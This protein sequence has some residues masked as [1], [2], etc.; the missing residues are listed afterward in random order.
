MKKKLLI[1]FSSTLIV[2]LLS[3]FEVYYTNGCPYHTGSPADGLTC[4]SC[5]YGGV[6][7]PTISINVL[8]A[9][10]P[11]NMYNPGTTYTISV[12]GIGYTFYGF[13]V[14]IINSQSSIAS[15]V[16]DFGI[17]NSISPSETINS[18]LPGWT[19]SDIMHTAPKSSSF[20]FEWTAPLSG[21]G[22]LYC[23][24]L[25]VNYN[26]STSGDHASFINMTLSPAVTNDVSEVLANDSILNVSIFPNPCS[27]SINIDYYL[28]SAT[29]VQIRLFD[30]NGIEVYEFL[31]I[32]QQMGQ[33]K[34]KFNI[35]HYLLKGLYFMKMNVF[36]KVKTKK[37]LL[38]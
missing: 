20:N 25:G 15:S 12:S 2:V 7:T 24:L 30:L 23:A 3:A 31:N 36:S 9:F 6:I 19:Y 27:E 1:F 37:I 5:H 26:G 34:L 32:E 28:K 16:L 38:K 14:E 33:H 22:Y 8:P 10:A 35:P 18:P 11:G 29:T 4:N 13:D 21:V 17:M